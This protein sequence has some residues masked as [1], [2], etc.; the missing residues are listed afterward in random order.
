[1][2]SA[3][4]LLVACSHYGALAQLEMLASAIMPLLGPFVVQDNYFGGNKNNK[5]TF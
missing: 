2:S 4:D 1:M 3:L 5:N